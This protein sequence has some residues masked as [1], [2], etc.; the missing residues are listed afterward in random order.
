MIHSAHL[1][2]AL[3][4]LVSDRVWAVVFPQQ[5][6][7]A[8]PAIRYTPV[9]AAISADACN[10]G[11]EDTD[12]ILVQIDYVATTYEQAVALC[13]QGRAALQALEVPGLNVSADSGMRVDPDPETKTLIAS[14]DFLFSGSSTS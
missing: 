9:A 13:T 11:S 14:Q 1:L 7:P 2:T 8:W 5:P 12:D 4:P 10:G 6:L 3:N